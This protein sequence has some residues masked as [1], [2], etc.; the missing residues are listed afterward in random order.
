MSY[1]HILCSE[2]FHEN[3]PNSVPKL[4]HKNLP[5]N[6]KYFRLIP[7][8]YKTENNETCTHYRYLSEFYRVQFKNGGRRNHLVNHLKLPPYNLS[9]IDNKTL[10]LIKENKSNNKWH[11]PGIYLMNAWVNPKKNEKIQLLRQLRLVQKKEI[12]KC[13]GKCEIFY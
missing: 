13:L 11:Q 7:N 6:I 8:K 4:K 3:R 9:I 12:S 5:N 10:K 1:F 2:C